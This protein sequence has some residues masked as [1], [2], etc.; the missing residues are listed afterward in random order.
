MT[1]KNIQRMRHIV[2]VLIRHGLY[3]IVE[4]MRLHRIVPFPARLRKRAV[5]ELSIPERIR[6][7]FEE[8]GPTFIKMGQLLSTRPDIL[9]EEY[10]EEFKKFQDRV[11]PFPFEKAVQQI[12]RELKSPIGQLF[13]KIEE[14]PIAAA[15]IAQVHRAVLLDGREVVVKVQRPGIEKTVDTDIGIMYTMANL[16]I[17]YF[18]EISLLQ[19]IAVV[20][21]FSRTIKREMDFTLEA[22]NTLKFR[23]MFK[24]DPHVYIPDLYWEYTSR[25]VLTLERIR[26]V[27]VDNVEK[28]R[29][30]GIDP[31]RIAHIIAETFLKMVMKEGFFHGDFHAGNIFVLGSERIALVDF[32]IVGR[33]DEGLR[34]S[35]ATIFIGFATQDYNMLIN[36]YERMG[37]LPEGI[38][39]SEFKR[40]YMDL[41]EP[42]F[43]KPFERTSLGELLMGYIRV[44]FRYGIRHPRELL[45][46]NKCIIE[47]EGIARILD[48]KAD[49]LKEAQPYAKEFI[50]ER[51]HPRR[52]VGE[53]VEDI[54]E[55]NTLVK[56]FP[57][58]LRQVMKKMIND[59]FTIDFVHLGLENFY[60]E[61]DRSS[62]RLSFALII[63]ALI[64]GSSM[65]I[66]TGI[67]PM[68]FGFPLLGLIGFGFAG[69][70]GVGLVIA[71]LRSGRF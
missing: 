10:I 25:R 4:R 61:I 17:R 49:L 23:E 60:N 40:D 65:V 24:G 8:L 30:R 58:Q 13:R 7:A 32:G 66:Q 14:I 59:K 34:D 19:P 1:Y 54:M 33:V 41:M 28:L 55:V 43:A 35:L 39:I 38:N 26:G 63:A 22:S 42:Y 56:E 53:V 20:D 31:E 36:E 57:S 47:I 70:M 6:L 67:G 48:P 12:E 46:I 71:I 62:N 51:Y 21:E 16:L 69:I 64:I 5:E 45:L 18:P 44:S 29:K 52:V 9:P 68:L 3:G 15:S 37:L 2:A 11:P 27:K 50:R